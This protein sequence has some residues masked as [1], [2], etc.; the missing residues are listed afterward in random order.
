MQEWWKTGNTGSEDSVIRPK[1]VAY[2]RHSAQDRQENSIPI[3]Q[4]QVRQFADDNGIE[5]VHEFL[6]RGKSGLTAAGRDGFQDMMENWVKT[7]SDFQFVLCLDVSRWGRFQDIDLSAQYSAEC[8]RHG[9]TV[10]YTSIGKPK[11]NDPL[12]SVY[13]QFER[14]RAAQYSRELSD[15]VFRGCAHASLRSRRQPPRLSMRLSVGCRGCGR[16]TNTWCCCRPGVLARR[17][18]SLRIL[19]TPTRRVAATRPK[20]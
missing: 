18:A 14:F 9:K 12:Y 15:K 3:Q 19:Q 6:D 7:K 4:E 17:F 16:C 5:I 20:T 2:Y 1:A 13:V 11:E 10:I 8:T